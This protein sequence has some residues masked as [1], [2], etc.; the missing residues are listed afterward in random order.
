[1]NS[2]EKLWENFKGLGFFG[3]RLNN[4][5]RK[6]IKKILDGI[7]FEGSIIDLGCGAGYT[8]QIFR[9]FGHS[10][11][12]GIDLSKNAIKLCKE[13]GFE[14]N[15]DIFL[16]N[17][18]NNGFESKSFDLVFSDGLLEHFEDFT[19]FVKEMCR[20]SRKY[21]LITQPNHFSLFGR[22]RN[23]LF[24]HTVKEY[25]YKIEDFEKEF[26]VYGFKLS[27]KEDINFKEMWILLFAKG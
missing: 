3:K 1:M 9:E 25:T 19:P 7:G 17:I 23:S 12:I 10:D 5:Q 11:S 21:V 6:K 24:P 27:K 15:K 8:L 20:L 18:L 13:K 26:R 2:W 22:I 14:E 16:K 4:E